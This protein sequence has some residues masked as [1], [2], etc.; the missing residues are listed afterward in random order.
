M[1]RH[2]WT[3]KGRRSAAEKEKKGFN[4]RFDPDS[5]VRM[6]PTV[7]EILDK[8]TEDP[9]RTTTQTDLEHNIDMVFRVVKNKVISLM[10]RRNKMPV[11]RKTIARAIVNRCPK[12]AAC[13]RNPAYVAARAESGHPIMTKDN[14]S[15]LAVART[16]N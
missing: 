16:A 9:T 2:G 12:A 11:A 10:Q 14:I 1:S 4:F 3:S 13:F 8:F 7:D 15:L 6:I 5:G